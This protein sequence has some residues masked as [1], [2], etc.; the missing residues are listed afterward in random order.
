MPLVLARCNCYIHVIYCNTLKHLCRVGVMK[1]KLLTFLAVATFCGVANA[2]SPFMVKHSTLDPAGGSTVEK[3]PSG[4]QHSFLAEGLIK[5]QHC[6]DHNGKQ[7]HRA[8]QPHAQPDHSP[9]E[10]PIAD[11]N[12]PV[13][14]T[15]VTN[16]SAVSSSV[17]TSA[18][19]PQ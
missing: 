9:I 17:A 1:Q 14:N 18:A 13:T 7:S 3:A 5:L 16:S 2:A 15:S 11:T 19:A 8:F 4:K 12:T 6:N 10:Q